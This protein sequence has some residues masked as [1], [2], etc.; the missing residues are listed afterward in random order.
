MS[1]GALYRVALFQTDLSLKYTRHGLH[2]YAKEEEH[3]A[4]KVALTIKELFNRKKKL[5][6]LD[7]GANENYNLCSVK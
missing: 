2:L 7:W 4:L 3:I 5:I 6:G 1:S